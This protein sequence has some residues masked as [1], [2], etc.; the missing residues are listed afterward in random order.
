MSQAPG[1]SSC[2]SAESLESK[3]VE[4]RKEHEKVEWGETLRRQKEESGKIL[5][6]KKAEE[7]RKAS[8]VSCVS[9]P[10]PPPSPSHPRINPKTPESQ[11]RVE[12]ASCSPLS[13]L[14]AKC[15]TR[16]QLATKDC[17]RHASGSFNPEGDSRGRVWKET[18]G[19][20][21]PATCL[22]LPVPDGARLR[23]YLVSITSN[24]R[25]GRSWFLVFKELAC[26]QRRWNCRWG[27]EPIPGRTVGMVLMVLYPWRTPEAGPST[28]RQKVAP[29]LR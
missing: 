28:H 13:P 20:K 4:E 27:R 1:E 3:A 12:R 5:A 23:V 9:P 26:T 25:A 2:L 24:P 21:S 6:E 11:L 14:P 15:T 29:P 19:G 7:A 22:P 10:P 18:R 8:Q 17:A 16:V